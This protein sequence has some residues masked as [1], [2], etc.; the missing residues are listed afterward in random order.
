MEKKKR[1]R[2]PKIENEI[3]NIESEKIEGNEPK[4]KGDVYQVRSNFFYKGVQFH[5]GQ[6]IGYN[7]QLLK[8]GKIVKVD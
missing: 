7:E 6:T 5:E 4:P 2:P 1:G 8:L 3:E